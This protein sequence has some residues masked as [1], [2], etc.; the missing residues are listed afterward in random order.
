MSSSTVEICYLCGLPILTDKTDDHV[1]QRLFVKGTQPKE[2]GF[3][4]GH[5][6]PTHRSCN[7]RFGNKGQGAESECRDALQ[8]VHDL[9]AE[10]MAGQRKDVWLYPRDASGKISGPFVPDLNIALTVMA[11]SATA[12]LV[13]W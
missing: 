10:I 1:L 3:K 9:H 12:F 11:K 13:R 4:Y 5:V 7:E 2:P 6:L 8:R